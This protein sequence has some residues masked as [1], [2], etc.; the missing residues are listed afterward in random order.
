MTRASL[1]TAT[2]IALVFSWHV[3]PVYGEQGSAKPPRP[4]AAQAG[5][6]AAKS[7]AGPSHSH[8]S[9]HATPSPKANPEGSTKKAPIAT[10]AS[11]APKSKTSPK[12]SATTAATTSTVTELTPLQQKLAKNTTLAGKLQPKLPEGTDLQTAALGFRNLGQFIAAVNVSHNLGIPFDKLK[13][14]MVTKNMSL[15]QAIHHLK[16]ASSAAVEAQHAEYEANTLIAQT[17]EPSTTP[18]T[19]APSTTKKK[20]TRQ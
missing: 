18:T 9:S 15:G 12:A 4:P 11:N 20:T 2:A 17:P 13:A 14:D 19:P 3:T 5:Q 1:V 7:P 16:P 8:E 10:T 6:A